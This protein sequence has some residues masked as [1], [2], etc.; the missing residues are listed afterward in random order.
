[1]D[2]IIR[3]YHDVNSSECQI[4]Y[5]VF[6]HLSGIYNFILYST[7]KNV[8][9]LDTAKNQYLTYLCQFSFSMEDNKSRLLTNS[10]QNTTVI[11]CIHF[12]GGTRTSGIQLFP[13]FSDNAD[14]TAFVFAQF[15]SIIQTVR[16]ERQL[17][18]D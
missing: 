17:R 15:D 7:N 12:N 5:I 10:N 3:T 1:M 8:R 4:I 14:Y 9:N 6:S 18:L 11:N 16:R 13:I 2:F